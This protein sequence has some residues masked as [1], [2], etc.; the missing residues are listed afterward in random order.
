MGE[1]IDNSKGKS[2]CVKEFAKQDRE[3]FIKQPRFST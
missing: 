2:F 1:K 3:I